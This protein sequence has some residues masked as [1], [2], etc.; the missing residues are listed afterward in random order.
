MRAQVIGMIE[1]CPSGSFLY[2]LGPDEPD[3]EPH[4]PVAVAVTTDD[5]ELA[6][7]LWV[8]GGVPVQRPT[9]NRSRSATAS[10]CV[11]AGSRRSSRCATVPTARSASGV[12]PPNPRSYGP[13]SSGRFT[14]PGDG[15]A[16][17][18]RAEAVSLSSVAPAAAS[19]STSTTAA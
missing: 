17:A 12:S 1:G 7:P 16:A 3:V 18:S 14:A 6:G 15:S 8:T 11:A 9:V 2:A 4:L 19:A 10:R 13:G 5:E